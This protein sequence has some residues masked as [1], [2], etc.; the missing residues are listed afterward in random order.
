MLD[1]FRPYSDARNLKVIRGLAKAVIQDVAPD[2]ELTAAKLTDQILE[3]Y[4]RGEV[5]VADTSLSDPGSFGSVDLV[6][7][8][9][10]P[11][12]VTTIGELCKQLVIWSIEEIKNDLDSEKISKQKLSQI[13][14]VIVDS[15]YEETDKK[16]KS[17]KSRAKGRKIPKAVKVRV[18]NYFQIY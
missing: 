5:L 3:K 17:K 11:L 4:E 2:E 15:K 6:T 9:V 18:K 16:V 8:V 7:L 13:I 12:L 1:D 10:I 14:D